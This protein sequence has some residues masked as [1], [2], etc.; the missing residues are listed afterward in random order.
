MASSASKVI[1]VTAKR[2]RA[3]PDAEPGIVDKVEVDRLLQ[4]AAVLVVDD[5]PGMRNF[6]KRALESRCALLEVA[7]SAEEA[8]ALRLRLHFDLMLVDIRLPGLSGLEWL[9]QLRDRGVLTHV[10]YMTAFADLEMAIQALR[11]G[12]DD[13]VMKPF[14]ID[15]MLHSVQRTLSRHQIVREN[16]LLRLQLDQLKSDQGVVGDSDA[17]VETLAIAQRVAPTQSTVLIQGETGTGK[18]LFARTIHAS[19][20]RSGPFVA[21]N[22]GTIAPELFESELFG[23]IK[24]AFTGAMQT[25][26]G[27]FVHADKG[28]VFRLEIDPPKI[29]V[30][31]YNSK[32]K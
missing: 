21:I 26:D 28:T 19:S 10:I 14:R 15:Q 22:C 2:S 9:R 11:N 1:D 27:L 31:Q 18:E 8:E 7:S 3:L 23:H 17:I 25:R 20:K 16:S 5:E 4:S 29:N 12:A 6:L 32:V 30:R 13:F 24:G